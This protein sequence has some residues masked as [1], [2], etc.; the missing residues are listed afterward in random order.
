MRRSLVIAAFSIVSAA[1]ETARADAL[2]DAL[3]ARCTRDERLSGAV[4]VA[5]DDPQGFEASELR[6]R[7]WRE[8]LAAPSVHALVLR[9][10]DGEAAV[11]ALASWL[12]ARALTP[13]FSRCAVGR[14]G[15]F[16][17]V[18]AVPRVVEVLAASATEASAWRVV[19]PLAL[20]D[21]TIVATSEG[22][23]VL[24]APLA[25]DGIVSI[26]LDP[27]RRWTL[28][29]LAETSSGP[30]PFATWIY[31]D[32]AQGA[33]TEDDALWST[34][35]VL[36]AINALRRSADV[37]ALRRDPVLD[38]VAARHAST[39]AR[40]G[41]LAHTPTPDD[42]PVERL[43]AAGV[44]SPRVAENL[45]RGRTLTEAHASLARSPS[46]RANLLDGAVDTVGLGVARAGGEVYLVEVFAR[47]MARDAPEP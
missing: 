8:G 23:A 36:G 42:T 12:D 11:D 14:R 10:G 24:R 6:A 19:S 25:D 30:A 16:L 3:D 46:H 40:R 29:V 4:A 2:G 27:R 39:L 15:E 7:V 1:S 13:S 26:A 22:A 37:G 41:I 35:H 34:R 31:G 9:G 33:V 32:S 18:A 5:L 47:R 44:T 20:R 21:A 38:D 17:A 43:R 28:Q 45:A